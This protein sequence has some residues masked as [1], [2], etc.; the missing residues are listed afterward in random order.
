MKIKTRLLSILLG[1]PL[2]FL[3]VQ[4]IPTTTILVTHRH[5]SWGAMQS[6]LRNPGY[7]WCYRC[8]YTW[9]DRPGHTVNYY[10]DP[11]GS[12]WGIFALCE[13]CWDQ[14]T[15]AQ[16]AAFYTRDYDTI[17]AD[18]KDFASHRQSLRNAILGWTYTNFFH[19]II[20]IRTLTNDFFWIYET[21]QPAAAQH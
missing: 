18:D 9:R 8:G 11:H 19:N 1:L 2:G 14:T 20:A 12:I 6:R 15:P 13:Q 5:Y 17:H 7:S 10:T 4:S 21:N 3:A 16:R